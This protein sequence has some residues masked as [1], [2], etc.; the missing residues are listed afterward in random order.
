MATTKN[1]IFDLG[2]VLIEWDAALG[3]SDVFTTRDAAEDWLRQIDFA[4]WNRLQD[5]GR[6]FA[7][8]LAAAKAEHGDLARHMAHYLTT[9]PVTID[10]TVPGTWE[11]LEDLAARD[12]PLYAITN[13]AADTWP[14]ALEL[15]PR[16]GTVFRD[17]VVS[18]QVALL[19][20]EP[21]IYRMLLDRNGLV[22][23]DCLFIDDSLPNVEGARA[24]GMDAIHFTDAEALAAELAARGLFA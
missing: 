5:G 12:V 21:A 18:G 24:V 9:F 20:P 23:Q 14:A 17:I 19:K 8:G 11:I 10:K 6:S 1:V 16:L 3:F 4:R 15:Y 13:W 22:A 2:A 7:D